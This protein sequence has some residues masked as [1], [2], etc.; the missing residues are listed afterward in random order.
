[1]LDRG[2]PLVDGL[3]EVRAASDVWIESLSA[4]GGPVPAEVEGRLRAIRDRLERP[5]EGSS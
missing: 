5:P 3:R 2:E 4:P 1:M